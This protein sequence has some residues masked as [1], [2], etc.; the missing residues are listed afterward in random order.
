MENA[1]ERMEQTRIPL[2]VYK[3]CNLYWWLETGVGLVNRF[4][5]LLQ[6]VTANNYNTTA[7]FNTTN[8]STLS[9]LSLLSLV[10]TW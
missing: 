9:L 3:Y 7:D 2:Q 5:D 6:G 8:H 1:P 10:F 4:I